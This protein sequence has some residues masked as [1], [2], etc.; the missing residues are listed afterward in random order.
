MASIGLA[1]SRI[2][3]SKSQG[4]RIQS[5]NDRILENRVAVVTGASRGL[6]KAMALALGGAGARLALIG[7]DVEKLNETAAECAKR[8]AETHVYRTDVSDE[9]QVLDLE[10]G[11]LA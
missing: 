8:G 3:F 6:G 11:V 7:R 2:V 1:R 5:M 10:K 9:A 4:A